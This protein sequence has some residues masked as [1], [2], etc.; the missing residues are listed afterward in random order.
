MTIRNR[1]LLIS[2]S[3]TVFIIISPVLVLFA[4]GYKFDFETKKIVKTGSLIVK[5]EPTKAT[6]FLDDKAMSDT[7]PSTL[8]FLVPK[9]YN[10]SVKKDGYKAWTKRLSI[11]SEIVTWANL[12]RE[13]IT[14]FLESPREIKSTQVTTSFRSPNS[15]SLIAIKDDAPNLID[16]EGKVK[17]LENAALWQTIQNSKIELGSENIYHL[18]AFNKNLELTAVELT[19][20][21]KIESNN[22]FL[23]TL[24]G[25]SVSVY[26]T[27]KQI[28]YSAPASNF[29][30]DG[31]TLWLIQNS[32]ISRVNLDNNDTSVIVSDLTAPSI[33]VIRGD[34]NIFLQMGSTLYILNDKLEQ[35]YN[36]VTYTFW[37]RNGNQLVYGNAHEIFVFDSGTQR[38]TLVLRSSTEIQQPVVNLETGYVFFTNEGK[39]KAI[40]IDG[41]DH[42]NI[43]NL[44]DAGNGFI[45][46]GDGK[47]LTVFNN[48]KVTTLEIR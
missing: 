5:S 35:I 21:K 9:D 1:I 2:V 13:F 14:L 36:N 33:N 37:S 43:Y 10:V 4:R 12:E 24:A 29:T 46:S 41:R 38:S 48:E 22:D 42:R 8:R 19:A 44:A 39:V 11:K 30:L 45:V 31:N 17:A 27:S 40:E 3:L 16:D 15:N 34:G 6:V 47:L 7:T 23:V 32:Q 18:L 26:N 25:P 20:I 28:V